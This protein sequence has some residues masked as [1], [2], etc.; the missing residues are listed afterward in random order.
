MTTQAIVREA[1]YQ[2]FKSDWA[3]RT[4]S[5]FGKETFDP[6]N[7]PWVRCSVQYLNTRQTTFGR[8]GNRRF[9]TEGIVTIQYF[10]PPELGDDVSDAHLRA[11]ALIFDSKRIMNNGVRFSAANAR[12]LGLVENKRWWA[13][14]VETPFAFD[15][16]R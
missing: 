12:G 10:E 1:I 11:A 2:I 16:I 14:V 13:G 9:E 15:E 3:D 5:C 6:V 8:P 4:P 7:A